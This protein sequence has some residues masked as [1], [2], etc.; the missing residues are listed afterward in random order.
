MFAATRTLAVLYVMGRPGPVSVWEA[1]WD[2]RAAGREPSLFS[3]VRDFPPDPVLF[4]IKGKAPMATPDSIRPVAGP[5]TSVCTVSKCRIACGLSEP[6]SLWQWT[7]GRGNG[8]TTRFRLCADNPFMASSCVP[9][10]SDEHDTIMKSHT[11]TYIQIHKYTPS[12]ISHANPPDRLDRC[13]SMNISLG[14]ARYRDSDVLWS[15]NCRF[16]KSRQCC[17]PATRS[18]AAQQPKAVTS[19]EDLRPL[20]ICRPLASRATRLSARKV[21]NRYWGSASVIN[22]SPRP[23]GRR[24]LILHM[25]RRCRAQELRCRTRT[26]E[27]RR[28][29]PG[30]FAS[31]VERCMV[32]VGCGRDP[33]SSPGHSE[34]CG[35][36]QPAGSAPIAGSPCDGNF[37]SRDFAACS[38]L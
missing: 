20:H 4:V 28:S 3:L 31:F 34:R 5:S 37:A 17:L 27:I 7:P 1:E 15:A 23:M 35:F 25:G 11:Y 16:D 24:V 12:C 14:S 33:F 22:R 21:A 19:R 2:R 30:G 13:D 29:Q 32:L 6:T 10:Q 36:S 38:I 18:R 9:S 8:A 26:D